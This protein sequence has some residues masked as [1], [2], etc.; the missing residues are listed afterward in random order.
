M[1]GMFSKAFYGNDYY[2]VLNLL[3]GPSEILDDAVMMFAS[4]LWLYMTP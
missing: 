2:G 1:Y 3:L 4:A